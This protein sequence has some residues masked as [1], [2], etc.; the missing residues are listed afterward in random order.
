M[1]TK[2]FLFISITLFLLIGGM[3]CEEDLNYYS[4][5]IIALDGNNGCFDIIQIDK[6][7]RG[8][9]ASETTISFDANSLNKSL[10]LNDIVKF[11]IISYEKLID[12]QAT[13][14]PHPT[15]SATIKLLNY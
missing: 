10:K 8:G 3:G 14:C 9:L 6:S 15:Y 5:T 7:P 2:T 12:T 13:L 1:K 4:G 11:E